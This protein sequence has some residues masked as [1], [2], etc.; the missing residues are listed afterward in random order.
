MLAQ[1]DDSMPAA[2]AQP[3]C[4]DD[5]LRAPLLLVFLLVSACTSAA[6]ENDGAADANPTDTISED[7]RLGDVAPNDAAS[8]D[9]ERTPDVPPVDASDAVSAGDGEGVDASDD[10]SD[11]GAWDAEGDLGDTSSESGPWTCATD[12]E[13]GP[14]GPCGVPRCDPSG[15]CTLEATEPD[16]LA[17]GSGR[18]CVGGACVS[19]STCAGRA[20]GVSCRTRSACPGRCQEERC[21]GGEDLDGATCV[22]EPALAPAS[23]RDAR[24]VPE[25]APAAVCSGGRVWRGECLPAAPAFELIAPGSGRDID[26]SRRPTLDEA[27]SFDTRAAHFYLCEGRQ[28]FEED[29][30]RDAVDLDTTEIRGVSADV[31][32]ALSRSVASVRYSFSGSAGTGCVS[33][34]E[35]RTT[36][37][38]QTGFNLIIATREDSQLRAENVGGIGWDASSGDTRSGWFYGPTTSEGYHDVVMDVW[39][40]TTQGDDAD[41][42]GTVHDIVVSSCPFNPCGATLVS[43]SGCLFVPVGPDPAV[44]CGDACVDLRTDPSNCG[45]CGNTCSD[46]EACVSGVCQCAP[47]VVERDPTLCRG[48]PPD[49]TGRYCE[50]ACPPDALGVACYAG[51]CVTGPSGEPVCACPESRGGD[52]CERDAC[53]ALVP[54][55]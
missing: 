16:E 27:D 41:A 47:D 7:V 44:L 32:A 33:C 21:R 9:A 23:C 4:R 51:R 19:E 31:R 17:C 22:G 5:A 55:P 49:R 35:T 11:V 10:A 53:G 20:N 34:A 46:Q 48:C 50:L 39:A 40:Q 24:C 25:T 38:L 18:I 43:D 15:R 1:I 2:R 3:A 42:S 26:A 54:N 8:S 52:H 36:S 30:A 13:C 28:D 37:S 6:R 14:P 29:G 12:S 45:S